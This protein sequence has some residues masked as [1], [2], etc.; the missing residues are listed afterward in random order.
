M[1]EDGLLVGAGG[2]VGVAEVVSLGEINGLGDGEIAIVGVGEA[3]KGLGELA[4]IRSG[5]SIGGA[6]L[7]VGTAVL[8]GEGDKIGLEVG[9][10]VGVVLGEL[11][12]R[13]LGEAVGPPMT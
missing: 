10:E 6:S 4:A 13:P 2:K 8:E 3:G 1:A 12:G 9:V 5:C 7:V 11:V